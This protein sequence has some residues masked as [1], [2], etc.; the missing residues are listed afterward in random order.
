MTPDPLLPFDEGAAKPGKE[1]RTENHHPE[2]T[3]ARLPLRPPACRNAPRGTSFTA[4]DCI[5]GHTKDL[6][7]HV[8]AYIVASGERGSTDDEGEAA[9]AIK[10]QA[11]TPRRR[12]LALLGLVRDSGR[13]RATA[14][15]RPAAVWVVGTATESSS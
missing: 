14:S 11:Y 6:R 5:A 3:L 12:E 10:P 15:G 13:R 1:G 4:A 8:L 9:L 7:A 2:D